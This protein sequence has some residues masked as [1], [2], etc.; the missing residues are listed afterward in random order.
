MGEQRNGWG[1]TLRGQD[2]K[3]GLG[4]P[5]GVYVWEKHGG[6]RSTWVSVWV[7]R[8]MGGVMSNN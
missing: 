4:R 3:C 1:V 5:H 8:W 2:V 6:T 7:G